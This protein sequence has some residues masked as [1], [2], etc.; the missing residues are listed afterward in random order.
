MSKQKNEVALRP[1][2]P[3]S[4]L[5]APPGSLEDQ[6]PHN[7]PVSTETG[8]VMLMNALCEGDIKIGDG[9]FVEI[10]VSHYCCTP[11]ARIDAD[12]GEVVEFNRLVLFQPD[13]STF[14]TTSVVAPHIMRRAISVY[15]AGP[16]NPPLRVMIRERKAK[17]FPGKYHELRF[18]LRPEG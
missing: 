4:T 11:G 13:G 14:V 18:L 9:G 12:T 15:G 7:L 16:W 10:A 2:I 17:N 5:I 6:W 3:P 8:K 1:S